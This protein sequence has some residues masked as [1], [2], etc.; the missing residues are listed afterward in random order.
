MT[1]DLPEESGD[2]SSDENQKRHVSFG[3]AC[4]E[5]DGYDEQD[6]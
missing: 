3:V 5:E 4:H 2:T 1:G 6:G